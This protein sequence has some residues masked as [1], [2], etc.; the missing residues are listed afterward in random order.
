MTH[1]MITREFVVPAVL[2]IV[3][4]DGPLDRRRLLDEPIL[5]PHRW[6]PIAPSPATTDLPNCQALGAAIARM[7]I[8]CVARS[9]GRRMANRPIDKREQYVHFA[10]HCLQLAKVA[11]DRES[12]ALLR[13]MAAEW[14]S[15]R[16]SPRLN[17]AKPSRMAFARFPLPSTT[18]CAWMPEVW[19]RSNGS[20]AVSNE[21]HGI[22]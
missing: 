18:G 19:G 20:R 9:E 22:G 17:P 14:L 15:W 11:Q 13:E 3:A 16:E 4:R 8:L 10:T 2:A 21:S 5:R 6:R 12:R 1:K 7:L